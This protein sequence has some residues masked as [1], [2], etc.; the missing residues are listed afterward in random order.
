MPHGRTIRVALAAMLAA[1]AGLAGAGGP[2]VTEKRPTTDAYHGVPVIDDY[3]WLENWDDPAVKSW[4]ETQNAYA[5]SVLDALVSRSRVPV[6]IEI[7]PSRMRPNDVPV[8]V[9]DY[10]RLERATLGKLSRRAQGLHASMTTR[11]LSL[12]SFSG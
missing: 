3:R 2:P 7:D 11:A 6:R 8:I 10:S 1:T 12:R 9:G 4:S 5:R